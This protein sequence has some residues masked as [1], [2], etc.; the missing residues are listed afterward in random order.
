MT[1]TTSAD[2]RPAG[3]LTI[4]GRPV[5]PGVPGEVLAYRRES[6]QDSGSAGGGPAFDEGFHRS[7]GDEQSAHARILAASRRLFHGEDVAV[8]YRLAD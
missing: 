7:L 3:R 6:T 2:H 5:L 8:P 4:G 1:P